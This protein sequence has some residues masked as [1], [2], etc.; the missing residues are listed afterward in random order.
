MT[1][2][3][4]R[5]TPLDTFVVDGAYFRAQARKAVKGF[6]LPLSGVIQAIIG[7]GEVNVVRA[8]SGKSPLGSRYQVK[9]RKDKPRSVRR[10]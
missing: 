5:Q 10:G 8:V 9:K 1:D 7:T 6:F 2:L 3:R 4:D